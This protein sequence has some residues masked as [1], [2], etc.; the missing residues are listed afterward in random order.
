MFI[1]E[2]ESFLSSTMVFLMILY[3]KSGWIGVSARSCLNSLSTEY[4]SR[5]VSSNRD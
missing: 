5:I 4:F 1:R 2:W 3:W